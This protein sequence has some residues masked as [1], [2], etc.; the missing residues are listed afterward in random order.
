[1]CLSPITIKNPYYGLGSKGINYLHNTSDSH[2]QVPC[3]HCRQC[4]SL[5]QG[6]FNQ[7]IQMESLRS[8]FFFF[9]LTYNN[10]HLPVVDI[11]EY[12]LAYPNI[13]HIQNLFKR[14]RNY[15]YFPLRYMVCSEY[16]TDRHR[17]HFHGLLAIPKK[18]NTLNSSYNF[19]P[20]EYTLSELF[21]SLW[22]EN[23]G[24]RKHPVYQPLF[25]YVSNHKGRNFDFHSVKPIKDHDND[26]SFYISKYLC[27]YDEYI[28]KL[29][30]KI[31]LD[32][33]VSPEDTK[34]LI[35]LIKP[36]CLIS[37][38]LG[39]RNYPQIKK[40]ILEC[41]NKNENIPS[42]YDINTGKQQLL[43]PYYRKLIPISYRF[44]QFYNLRNNIDLDSFILDDNMD[45]Y[46]HLVQ[47]Q[48]QIQ[49]NE[50]K[51]FKKYLEN[52]YK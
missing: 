16:G 4:I 52:K 50:L 33:N 18:Y 19:H 7:R 8:D 29:I 28:Q 22:S 39:D 11:G 24:T 38:S 36:R 20:L 1:M 6:Y 49:K 40:Y 10:E 5:R 26:I 51:N 48:N 25:T 27:Q 35:N 43:S 12:H 45:D 17:P 15:I 13:Q 21:K 14:L 3:G 47:Y 31:K 37:K 44:N 42:F 30:L 34:K 2:I 32:V 9:T 23:V 46:E 41:V